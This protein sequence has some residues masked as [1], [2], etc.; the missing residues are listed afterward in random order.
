MRSQQT[1]PRTWRV[2]SLSLMQSELSPAGARYTELHRARL[3]GA[4][5]DTA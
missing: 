1:D 4:A 3:R 5:C 2:S